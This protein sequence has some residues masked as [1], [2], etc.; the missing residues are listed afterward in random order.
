VLCFLMGEVIVILY[1]WKLLPEGGAL[2]LSFYPHAVWGL[3]LGVWRIQGVARHCTE[4]TSWWL[5]RV[6]GI[7]LAGGAWHT[8]QGNRILPSELHRC[9]G[10]RRLRSSS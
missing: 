7:G 5:V 4:Q 9:L 3:H 6:V 8:M 10:S 1:W 2:V